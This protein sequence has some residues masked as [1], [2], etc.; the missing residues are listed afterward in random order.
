[1]PDDSVMRK[2]QADS[3]GWDADHDMKRIRREKPLADQE[4]ISQQSFGSRVLS[5]LSD[6]FRS[7]S[8]SPTITHSAVDSRPH[9][10]FGETLEIRT[11][12]KGEKVI[13]TC[14]GVVITTPTCFANGRERMSSVAVRLDSCGTFLKIHEEATD[15][16]LGLLNMST[17]CEL[18][19]SVTIRLKAHMSPVKEPAPP[20]KPKWSRGAVPG[21]TTEYNLR[22]VV[23]GSNEDGQAVGRLLSGADL[24]LQHPS[25]SECDPSL[26]YSNP[27][28]LILPGGGMP[29]LEDLV[30]E[31]IDQELRSKQLDDT[32]KAR[33]LR[34]FDDANVTV[35]NA[36]SDI[37]PSP[38][39]RTSLM[40]HQLKALSMMVERESGVIESEQ[41]P[42]LWVR[43]RN[44]P[45]QIL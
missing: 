38:R 21:P 45:D 36:I 18:M 12:S 2:R 40:P 25:A 16:Y 5:S 19:D 13:D 31:D 14:F 35:S 33:L 39:L 15:K 34:M 20:R 4:N 43:D 42:L 23:E 17:L 7:P 27:Q 11:D 37:S 8:P 28:F 32:A 44:E 22:I 9:Q 1:M 10:S 30:I 6:R 24:F 3:S 26:V 29:T 41:F